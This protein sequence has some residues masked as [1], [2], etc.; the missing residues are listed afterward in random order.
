MDETLNKAI[1]LHQMGNIQEAIQSYN[2]ILPNNLSNAPLH[3]LLGVANKEIGNFRSSLE[4][5][6]Q[7]ILLDHCNPVVHNELGIVLR[8]FKLLNESLDSFDRAV[9]LKLDYVEGLSNRGNILK[10]LNRLDEALAS[11]DRAI[12]IKPDY[13]DAHYNRSTTLQ[14]LMRLDEA[15]AGYDRVIAI[16]PA[17][18]KARLNRSLARLACGDFDKGWEEYEWRWKSETLGL[19]KRNVPQPLWLGK[20]TLSGKTILLHSEQGLGDTIQFCRYAS[21]VAKLG[22]QVVLEV[23]KLLTRLLSNLAGPAQLIEEGNALPSFDYHCPLMSLP[24]A[25]KSDVNSIPSDIPYI[26]SDPEKYEYWRAKLGTNRKPR[27]GLV[28]SG[29]FRPNQ[30]G[31]WSVNERR[32]I[33]L[34]KL[35]PLRD[36]DVEFYSLQKGEP[37]KT[38]LANLINNNWNGPHIIDFTSELNDFSDTAALIDNLDLVISVDT[39]TAHLAGAMGK[40]VWIINRFDTCW[41]W[42]LDRADSPWYPT[43]RLYR[44][45]TAGN[46]D[47]VI[48]RIKKDLLS[49]RQA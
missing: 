36:V 27:A 20:E 9:A 31:T 4:F 25:F 19:E 22:A 35:G 23:P 2:T 12:A 5:L 44:Q 33:P 45:E 41:R 29:G 8:Q 40:D 28:W 17:H 24:L 34:A 32:N 26:K 13:V 43:A 3:Y 46:W 39:S 11:Y 21:L 47:L 37:A 10:E 30:P 16:K 7:S 49:Y 38:E 1:Q 18:A 15:L 48:N 14:E 42:L 6:I